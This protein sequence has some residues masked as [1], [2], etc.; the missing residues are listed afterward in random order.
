MKER[1]S[2]ETGDGT[3]GRQQLGSTQGT[4]GTYLQSSLADRS[5]TKPTDQDGVLS[6]TEIDRSDRRTE[7]GDNGRHQQEDERT[8][9]KTKSTDEQSY[10]AASHAVNVTSITFAQQNLLHIPTPELA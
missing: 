4:A 5:I 2:I 8:K 1:L 6:R 7:N 10:P 3:F 9:T